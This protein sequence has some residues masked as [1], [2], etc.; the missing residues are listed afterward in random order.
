MFWG[1]F[2]HSID[3]KGRVAIPGKWRGLLS[4]QDDNRIVLTRYMLDGVRCLDAYPYSEWIRFMEEKVQQRRLR[5]A[6]VRFESYYVSRAHDCVMDKQGRILIPPQLREY[7]NL[8]KDV[9][10]AGGLSK[11]RLWDAEAWERVDRAAEQAM[12]DDP[13]FLEGPG[14]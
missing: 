2:Q 12:M 7:A 8:R 5:Q 10:F 6:F 11:F 14:Q 4:G 1:D 13:D 3:E 9:V